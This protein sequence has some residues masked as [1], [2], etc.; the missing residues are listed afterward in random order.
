ML[1]VLVFFQ[2]DLLKGAGKRERERERVGPE[3]GFESNNKMKNKYNLG[4]PVNRIARAGKV[5]S[6]REKEARERK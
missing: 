2:S 1:L 5:L 4:A 3:S 6:S